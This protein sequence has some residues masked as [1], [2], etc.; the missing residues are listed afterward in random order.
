MPIVSC[1]FSL[2]RFKHNIG[3]IVPPHLISALGQKLISRKISSRENF[4]TG[5]SFAIFADDFDRQNRIFESA[6]P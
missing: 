5:S 6:F 3:Q 1:T 2:Q 4:E